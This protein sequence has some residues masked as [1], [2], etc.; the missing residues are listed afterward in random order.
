FPHVSE[1]AK[2]P[3]CQQDLDAVT[4][5]RLLDFEEFV[6]GA[7]EKRAMEAE[8]AYQKMLMEL[9]VLPSEA[10]WLARFSAI[11]EAEQAAVDVYAATGARL[12][13]MNDATSVEG[14]PPADFA[15]LR[16]LIE[17]RMRALNA[18]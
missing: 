13:A 3:L 1:G 5:Q 2:C 6:K 8:A 7:V 10:D 15:P 17:Q 4:G 16:A 11:P 18:E 12:A 14:V 9:P